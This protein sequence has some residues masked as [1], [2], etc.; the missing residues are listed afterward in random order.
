[1]CLIQSAGNP[2][3]RAQALSEVK[4]LS[5]AGLEEVSCHKL[6][7]LPEKIVWQRTTGGL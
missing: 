6:K 5:I 2:I 1:M 4:K 3:K 7:E